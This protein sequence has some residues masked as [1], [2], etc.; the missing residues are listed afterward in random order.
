MQQ[1]R[2]HLDPVAANVQGY[3]H[4]PQEDPGGVEEAQHT[5]EAG[6]GTP[7]RHHV[8]NCSKTGAYKTKQFGTPAL[9]G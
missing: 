7:I 9:L 5:D 2:V 6:G 4:L 1:G 8:Q 3:Q